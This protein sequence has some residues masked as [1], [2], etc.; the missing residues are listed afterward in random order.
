MVRDTYDKKVRLYN[1]NI[2]DYFRS[3]IVKD[4]KLVFSEE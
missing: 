1:Y 2:D 3:G 4:L